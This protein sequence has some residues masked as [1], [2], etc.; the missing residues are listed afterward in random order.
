M[1]FLYFYVNAE[2]PAWTQTQPD[3]QLDLH[4]PGLETFAADLE[5]V[6]RAHQLD[7]GL[8]ST[9]PN[10]PTGFNFAEAINSTPPPLPLKGKSRSQ[11]QLNLQTS[12]TSQSSSTQASPT[13]SFAS[14]MST[15]PSYQTR[16][17]APVT[18]RPSK[19]AAT[20]ARPLHSIIRK[21]SNPEP[22][23]SPTE[24]VCTPKKVASGQREYPKTP[25][26]ALQPLNLSSA[27]RRTSHTHTP[28]GAASNTSRT[29]STA[30]VRV[31]STS[32]SASRP[33]VGL[34]HR[35]SQTQT[36]LDSRVSPR[37]SPPRADVPVE[38]RHSL[39]VQDSL[40]F[41]LP[42]PIPTGSQTNSRPGHHRARSSLDGHRFSSGGSG[43]SLSGGLPS[44]SLAPLT[45]RTDRSDGASD[46]RIPARPAHDG[47]GS[48]PALRMRT[49]EEKTEVLRGMMNNVDALLEGM[50]RVGIWGL[51]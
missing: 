32:S 36:M 13:Q 2:N 5:A 11:G 38:H 42:P 29:P 50:S 25:R 40:A 7:F 1:E 48:G 23:N 31:S 27:P 10:S 19:T 44:T 43:S 21:P 16:N 35:R 8:M 22:V 39:N 4:L 14:R 24:V 15:P 3:T 41:A 26:K 9:A 46:S 20:P 51:A 45:P 18:P 47:L 6:H 49:K 12:P 34:G 28:G 17:P 37:P 30:S 33:A